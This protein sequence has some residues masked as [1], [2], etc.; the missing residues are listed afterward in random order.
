MPLLIKMK[1][2]R[3]EILDEIEELSIPSSRSS[4][5]LDSPVAVIS[6]ETEES[7]FHFIP[8]GVLISNRD[9]VMDTDGSTGRSGPDEVFGAGY[10]EEA[11]F[12][13]TSG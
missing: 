11:G 10:E 3:L 5:Q 9:S 2:L 13:P 4:R 6:S 8:P 1:S 12:D 7:K